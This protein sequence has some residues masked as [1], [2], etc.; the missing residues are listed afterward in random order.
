MLPFDRFSQGPDK[1]RGYFLPSGSM[2]EGEGV[3]R[4]ARNVASK[5][6]QDEHEVFF[7]GLKIYFFLFQEMIFD[8]SFDT[9]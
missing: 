9:S 8:I 2:S 3:R 4:S 6:E 5:P 1:F 7:N